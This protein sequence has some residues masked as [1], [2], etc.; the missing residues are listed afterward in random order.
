MAA[1][2]ETK[3]VYACT[4]CKRIVIVTFEND[5]VN[6]EISRKFCMKSCREAVY[7]LRYAVI[8]E[9]RRTPAIQ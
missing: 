7:V 6:V 4:K 2:P 9:R 1:T 3:P 8:S 5:R